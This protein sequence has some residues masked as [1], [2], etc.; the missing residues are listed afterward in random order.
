MR[1]ETT[2]DGAGSPLIR[3]KFAGAERGRQLRAYKMSSGRFGA[4]PARSYCDHHGEPIRDA[5]IV[6]KAIAGF[7]PTE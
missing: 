2:V 6:A 1:G 3:P 7:E 5:L 4:A